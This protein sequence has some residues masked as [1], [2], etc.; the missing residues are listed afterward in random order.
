[1]GTGRAGRLGTQGAET[2]A[3]RGVL[4][5]WNLENMRRTCPIASHHRLY[6]RLQRITSPYPTDRAN[7][8]CAYGCEN[9][10]L[11]GRLMKSLSSWKSMA[12]AAERKNRGRQRGLP[13]PEAR[14]VSLGTR[15]A[16][17]R[18]LLRPAGVHHRALQ[19]AEKT[20]PLEEV[21]L[22]WIVNHQRCS[23]RESEGGVEKETS[24]A[25]NKS[26]N[27]L[28]IFDIAGQK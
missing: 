27:L 5:S 23:T 24:K 10:S 21:R 4:A 2:A 1:M 7:T 3:A 17:R 8:W 9:S 6:A 28:K 13:R 19:A 15:R 11:I 22:M 16:E 26:R 12:S 14:L 25:K 20:N 18:R